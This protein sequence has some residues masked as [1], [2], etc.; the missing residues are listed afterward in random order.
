MKRRLVR[1][2]VGLAAAGL[3]ISGMP[4]AA[5]AAPIP[6]PPAVCNPT[7]APGDPTVT[8]FA[9]TPAAVNVTGGNKL[10]TFTVTAKG[11]TKD[12]TT[13]SVNLQSPTIGTV[14]RYAAAS[15]RLK[16]GTKR[17]GVWTGTA[18]IPRWTNKGTW[19]ISSVTVS[20]KGGGF[21]Y[22]TPT[23][24]S[25]DHAWKPAWPKTLAVA[26]TPDVTPPAVTSLTVSPKTVDTSSAPKKITVTAKIRDGQSGVS[27]AWVS[28]TVKI[29]GRTYGA[30]AFLVRKA[31]T[32]KNGT[33][34]GTL[35]VPK[36]VGA[37]THVWSLT[38]YVGDTMGNSLSLSTAALKQKH[39]AFSFR[40]KSRTDSS[41]PV[42]KS[43]A[44]TPK[45]V[46]ARAA[47]K[48]VAVTLG[49]ADTMSGLASAQV[50]FLS[51]SGSYSASGSLTGKFGAT[52]G[53]WKGKVTVGRCSEPGIW[54]LFSIVVTDVSGNRTTLTN[55]QAK[56]RHFPTSLTVKAL[57]AVSPSVKFPETVGPNG[58]ITFTFS[59]PTLFSDLPGD[60]L[61]VLDYDTP[62][63]WVVPGTWTCKKATGATVACDA[64]GAAVK[65]MSFKSTS[66]LTSGH[67][68]SI[69]PVNFY[70]DPIGIYDLAGNQLFSLFASVDVT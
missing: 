45:S 53:T 31:G 46:D 27:G 16:S 50:T 37:S 17:N 14:T 11:T 1:A 26:S 40:V 61:Q 7:Y 63:P 51:P 29:S 60:L 23:I 48:T 4:V 57:D 55:A 70:P 2:G 64:A 43:F 28:G 21:G 36:W 8:A 58:A 24:P 25:G 12:V 52:S 35:T 9:R 10:V 33:F 19:K 34:V 65:T 41:K 68:I 18:T 49:L 20:D 30:T 13:V 56:A 38:A 62:Y 32:A 69:S 47:N 5:Q 59:E 44:F 42:V 67:T 39:L 66:A 22:Y 3:V 54:T 15:L 6:T